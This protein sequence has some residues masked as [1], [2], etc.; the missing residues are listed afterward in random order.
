[1]RRA[2]PAAALT[3]EAAAVEA[4]V[5]IVVDTVVVG[6]IVVEVDI[7]VV[8]HSEVEAGFLAEGVCID[9]GALAL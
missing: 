6:D 5:D 9:P 7:V 1:L 3:E 2:A 4:E 8:V